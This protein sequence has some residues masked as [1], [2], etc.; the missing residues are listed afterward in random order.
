MIVLGSAGTTTEV[1]EP[2]VTQESFLELFLDPVAVFQSRDLSKII[3][4]EALAPGAHEVDLYH[5]PHLSSECRVVDTGVEFPIPMRE[6]GLVLE[7]FAPSGQKVLRPSEL[8]RLY[9]EFLSLEQQY[10]GVRQA[11]L[12]EERLRKEKKAKQLASQ[13][14]LTAA[15]NR[16]ATDKDAAKEAAK[17]AES[18]KKTAEEDAVSGLTYDFFLKLIQQTKASKQSKQLYNLFCGDSGGAK[19]PLVNLMIGLSN[20]TS[21]SVEERL[22]FCFKMLCEE[23]PL[24]SKFGKAASRCYVRNHRSTASLVSL[25]NALRFSFYPD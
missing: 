4:I 24:N 10:L 5:E 22:K 17:E 8:K 2:C 23:P 15:L 7:F 25:Q 16:A 12:E 1:G 20:F 18:K 13:D 14:P 6:R 9:K 3:E 19:V 21:A 11:Q